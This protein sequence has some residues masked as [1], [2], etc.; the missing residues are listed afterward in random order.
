MNKETVD[1][2]SFNAQDWDILFKAEHPYKE[3]EFIGFGKHEFQGKSVPLKK[4]K[5]CGLIRSDIRP[6]NA[7]QD[8]F[9]GFRGR[10]TMKKWQ[11]ILLSIV[12]VIIGIVI[13]YG[14][15]S[16]IM[17]IVARSILIQ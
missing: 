11:K 17:Y 10:K 1:S 6:V 3:H 13:G 2:S 7:E 4:C 14:L 12:F 8:M 5:L 16:V 15:Y 9:N